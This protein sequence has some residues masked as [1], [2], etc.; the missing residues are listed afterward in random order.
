VRLTGPEYLELHGALRDAFTQY[1][2]LEIALRGA[3]FQLQD[4]AA[5]GPMPQVVNAVIQAAE[6]RDACTR[7][8]KPRARRTLR[9]CAC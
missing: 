4:I 1:D 5:R 7:S 2:D 6:T 8:S 3:G 9:T